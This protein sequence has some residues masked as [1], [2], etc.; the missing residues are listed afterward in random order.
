MDRRHPACIMDRRHLACIMDRR[1]PACLY[2]I[3]LRY[4]RRA[5]FAFFIAGILVL[6]LWF[7]RRIDFSSTV[8]E[9]FA[10]PDDQRDAIARR[11][12]SLQHE[13]PVLYRDSVLLFGLASVHA[14]SFLPQKLKNRVLSNWTSFLFDN[15]AI[16]WPYVDYPTVGEYQICNGLIRQEGT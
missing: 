5:F 2:L 9:Y 8:Q 10:F 16:S 3:K 6:L 13:N 15:R 12:K 1:H 14:A 11:F 4:S 7:Y